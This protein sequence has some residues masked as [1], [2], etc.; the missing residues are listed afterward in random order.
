M[1]FRLLG[2][3]ALGVCLPVSSVV[4][5]P[6]PTLLQDMTGTWAVEQRMWPGLGAA[7]VQLPS[8]VAQ[9]KL[10]DGKFLEEAMQPETLVEGQPGFFVRNATLNFNAVSR[11]YEYFSIDTRAPQMM[12]ERSLPTK[13]SSDASKE[14]KLS[15]ATF[16]APEWGPAK[17]VRFK[18]RLTVGAVQGGRQTVNLY[19]TPQSVLPKK[20]FLAFEYKYVRQP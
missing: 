2:S 9:R 15:G 7:A 5:Q 17:N 12:T 11:Q 13:P 10:I 20:E 6:A 19:L 14:L 8:G 4:A 1:L 18:Y 16:V 3:I